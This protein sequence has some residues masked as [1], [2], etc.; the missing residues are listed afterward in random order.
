MT[1]LRT[2]FVF[3]KSGWVPE[4][5]NAA[6]TISTVTLNFDFSVN[7]APVGMNTG[8]AFDV[9]PGN[10]A[11][12]ISTSTL[13]FDFVANAPPSGQDQVLVFDVEAA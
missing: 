7:S 12:T 2:G 3:S 11:P 4:V 10:A 9:L 1:F 5:V 6:P 8:L 13:N